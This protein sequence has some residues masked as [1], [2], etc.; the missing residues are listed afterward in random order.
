MA[1][2]INWPLAFYNEVLAEDCEQLRSAFRLGTLYYD[3][4][5]W[6][7]GEIVDIRVNHLKVR[8]GRIEGDL[9]RYRLKE[10]GADDL[11][12][13]KTALQTQA[14]VQAFLQETYQQT[15]TE[16]SW[17]TVVT[18]KNLPVIP[19]EIESAD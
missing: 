19:E 18:Y 3:H 1:K 15:V 5:Y 2:A 11:Q 8:Q 9:K 12:C 4:H 17:I 6:T 10:L 14:T 7:A 13:Q 16:D